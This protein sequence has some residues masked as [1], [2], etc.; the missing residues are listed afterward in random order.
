LLLPRAAIGQWTARRSPTSQRANTG[1]LFQR[2]LLQCVSPSSDSLLV[3]VPN[4]S[5][6]AL[7]RGAVMPNPRLCVPAT[8]APVPPGVRRF[9]AFVDDRVRP[10]VSSTPQP[11]AAAPK[12][13]ARSCATAST[14]SHVSAR[15]CALRDHWLKSEFHA[16]GVVL[17]LCVRFHVPIPWRLD[18]VT[19]KLLV[20][21][22]LLCVRRGRL[23][24]P[25]WLSCVKLLSTGT[26]L[27]L[28]CVLCSYRG[29]ALGCAQLRQSVLAEDWLRVDAT[30][31]HP[32][33]ASNVAS[34]VA[35][36]DLEPCLRVMAETIREGLLRVIPATALT[37]LTC[38]DMWTLTSDVHHWHQL[39]PS[40]LAMTRHLVRPVQLFPMNRMMR[41]FDRSYL[42]VCVCVCVCVCGRDLQ[43]TMDDEEEDG[44]KHAEDTSG[45]QAQQSSASHV[46]ARAYSSLG[47]SDRA[48]VMQW[49]TGS[50]TGV[51]SF[52]LHRRRTTPPS[53]SL[54]VLPFASDDVAPAGGDEP[55]TPRTDTMRGS[56]FPTADRW[57]QSVGLPGACATTTTTE[58]ASHLVWAV[59]MTRHAAQVRAGLASSLCGG[60]KV[61]LSFGSESSRQ[62]QNQ[63]Q[64]QVHVLECMAPR[65]VHN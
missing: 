31:L 39:V 59:A 34:N 38:E 54:R 17:G 35:A 4:A 3:P 18:R 5:T 1:A 46:F 37:L 7:F 15:H 58:C 11:A 27:M 43:L 61:P 56:V 28:P 14:A 49:A 55:T 41:I 30:R 51:A 62:N 53:L 16:L 64:N 10:T 25:S 50:A 44:A 8:A 23:P 13:T 65:Q 57:T 47:V 45:G 60:L 63:N 26:V 6:S 21:G 2:L 36:H 24:L 29:L 22:C 32:A 40:A 20:R 19:L 12:P 42:C 33:S 52:L 48:C 9:A